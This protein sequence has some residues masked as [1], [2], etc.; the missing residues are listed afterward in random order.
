MIEWVILS[1]FM[2]RKILRV[3]E[4][5]AFCPYVALNY[6]MTF[7]IKTSTGNYTI[8]SEIYVDF[9]KIREISHAISKTPTQSVGTEWAGCPLRGAPHQNPRGR[10]LLGRAP[11]LRGA[12]LF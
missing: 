3:R 6:S 12:P 8:E 1:Y 9:E 5:D 2:R 11:F 4:N 10:A 7:V